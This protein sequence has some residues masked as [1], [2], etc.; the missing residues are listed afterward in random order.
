MESLGVKIGWAFQPMV[1]GLGFEPKSMGYEPNM[2][3]LQHP[4]IYKQLG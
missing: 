1:A 2:L 3:P 4:A